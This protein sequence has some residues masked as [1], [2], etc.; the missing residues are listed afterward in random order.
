[1]DPTL[2]VTNPR[3]GFVK[4]DLVRQAWIQVYRF[5]TFLEAAYGKDLTT[6]VFRWDQR[7]RRWIWPAM[8]DQQLDKLDGRD[9]LLDAVAAEYYGSGEGSSDELT[10]FVAKMRALA[11]SLTIVFPPQH[12]AFA[13]SV[14]RLRP[15]LQRMLIERLANV[16]S[17]AGVRFIDCSVGATCGLSDDM[18]FDP[19]HPNARGAAA[20]TAFLKAE[21]GQN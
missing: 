15:G 11:D 5:Q 16:A 2:L 1:M 13:E 4:V 3:E 19:V 7:L 17:K 18:F 12:P 8:Q 20:F 14:N 10:E 6:N 21:L 9:R